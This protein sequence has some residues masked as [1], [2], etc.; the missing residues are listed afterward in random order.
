MLIL[1]DEYWTGIAEQMQRDLWDLFFR[2]IFDIATETPQLFNSRQQLITAIRDGRVSYNDGIWTGDFNIGISN[3]LDRFAIF[4]RRSKVWRGSPPPDILAATVVANDRAQ[5]LSAVLRSKLSEL[6]S[7]LEETIL[8]LSYPIDSPLLQMNGQLVRDIGDISIIP[9]LTPEIQANLVRDYNLNQQLSI[10]N[11]QPEQVE[12]LRAM[13]ERFTFRG[14]RRSELEEMILQEWGVT[15]NKARFLARQETSLFMSKLRRERFTDAG[16]RRYRWSTSQ[17]ERVRPEGGTKRDR[18]N[19]HR[20]LHGLEFS[21]GDPPIV[22]TN[23][24][25][26]AEPGEDYGCRCTAIPLLGAA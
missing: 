17:D 4:D 10:K 14:Y 5:K 16:V 25:R 23:T 7:T 13:I 21:F 9:T 15:A 12:R 8:R 3:E 11:W 1:R 2:P 19:N 6:E 20:M 26:R 18:G 24:G 22:D